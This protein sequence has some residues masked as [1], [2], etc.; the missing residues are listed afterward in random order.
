MPGD[1]STARKRVL[2]GKALNDEQ[3]SDGLSNPSL[4]CVDNGSKD[5][6]RGK[7]RIQVSGRM[8]KKKF[9]AGLP[10]PHDSTTNNEVT[11]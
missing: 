6:G 10:A 1:D 4:H 3:R 8:Y 9:V 7:A 11:A 5:R 2:V